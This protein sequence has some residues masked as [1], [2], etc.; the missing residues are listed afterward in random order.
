[1]HETLQGHPRAGRLCTLLPR[2]R[3]GRR[4][5][6]R[7]PLHGGFLNRTYP[8]GRPD[9]QIRHRRWEQPL[10]R[11]CQPTRTARHRRCPNPSDEDGCSRLPD[12]EHRPPHTQPRRHPRREHARMARDCSGLRQRASFY[13]TAS[14]REE[15]E[16]GLL[17]CESNPFE[18]FP[19]RQLALVEDFSWSTPVGSKA[20]MMSLSRHLRRTT[21]HPHGSPKRR[22]G[23]SR[24]G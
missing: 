20:S 10:R 5:R 4:R 17:C 18:D 6:V 8:P 24:A 13:Y 23:S 22:R 21:S 7:M 2:T 19:S 9:S 1:M 12:G 11:P 16:Q 15:L 3:F 14:R